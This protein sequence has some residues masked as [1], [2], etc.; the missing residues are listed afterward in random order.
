[1]GLDILVQLKALQILDT[2]L[3]DSISVPARYWNAIA[4]TREEYQCSS[5]LAV[6]ISKYYKSLLSYMSLDGVFWC[7]SGT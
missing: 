5:V 1:M 6:T 3:L 4:C 7:L 2:S